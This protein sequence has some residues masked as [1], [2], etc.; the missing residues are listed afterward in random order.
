MA[1]PAVPRFNRRFI[2]KVN[3]WHKYSYPDAPDL[4]EDE[5]R[6]FYRTDD[7]VTFYDLGP[8][9]PPIV[10]GPP[11]PIVVPFQQPLS[12]NEQRFLDQQIPGLEPKKA[13]WK[14]IKCLGQGG[15]VWVGMW[16]YNGPD[17]QTPWFTTVAVKELTP[18][19]SKFDLEREARIMQKL[20]KSRSDHI[21]ALLADPR[22]VDAIAEGLGPEWDGRIRRLIME[23]CDQGTAG[24]LIER[25]FERFV[26]NIWR[27]IP[28][29]ADCFMI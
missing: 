20:N 14:G 13:L 29:V 26:E 8:N 5:V 25:R 1:N 6:S 17:D 22:I 9:P 16:Q 11:G 12:P 4:T 2:D 15:F 21:V 10:R 28:H 7:Y 3:R 18:D 24:D 27:F 19:Q 23:Y